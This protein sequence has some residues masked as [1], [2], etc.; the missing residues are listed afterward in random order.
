MKHS[1]VKNWS[2]YYILAV[3]ILMMSVF[4]AS[5]SKDDEEETITDPFP[6]VPSGEIVPVSERASVLTRS[7]ESSKSTESDSRYWEFAVSEAIISGCGLEETLD[8]LEEYGYDSSA[9]IAFG[10]DYKI[11]VMVNSVETEVGGWQWD[12]SET[13]TGIVLDTYPGTVFT[14]TVLNK[15]SVVYASKQT[16]AYEACPNTT[17]ITYEQLTASSK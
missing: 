6:G 12:N 14:F 7:F 4:F 15:T 17:I 13:K 11:Y 2:A 5:C 1:F 10:T 3:G 8:L 9:K 16:G